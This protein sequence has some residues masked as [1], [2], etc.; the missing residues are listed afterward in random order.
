MSNLDN[1]NLLCF[2]SLARSDNGGM[3]VIR[4]DS[5]EVLIVTRLAAWSV[6]GSVIFPGYYFSGSPI[7]Q[8]GNREMPGRHF[9]WEGSM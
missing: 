9:R 1:C 4:E 7:S 3:H 8:M 5:G 2:S 6:T